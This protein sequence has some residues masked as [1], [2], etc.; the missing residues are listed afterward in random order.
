[1]ETARKENSKNVGNQTYPTIR[2]K[3]GRYAERYVRD[4]PELRREGASTRE[5]GDESITIIEAI[6]QARRCVDRD[7]NLAVFI[8]RD[9][10]ELKDFGMCDLA[11]A[12]YQHGGTTDEVKNLLDKL[13]QQLKE[14]KA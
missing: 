4:N 1:L 9:Y 13:E 8:V 14:G 3:L 2:G 10:Q 6:A 11:W 5:R 7:P 12:Y